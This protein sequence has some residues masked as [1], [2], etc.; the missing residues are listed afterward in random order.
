MSIAFIVDATTSAHLGMG[1]DLWRRYPAVR[2][3]YRDVQTWTGVDVEYLSMR[4]S[5]PELRAAGLLCQTAL[6]FAIS[7]ILAEHGI[8]PSSA[9]GLS[10]GDLIA[11]C[12]AG[13]V[14]REDLCRIMLR[15][16][17]AR[18]SERENAD[19]RLALL[20]VPADVDP[21]TFY[22]PVENVHLVTDL[23]PSKREENSKRMILG[24]REESL[25]ELA[26]ARR[27]GVVLRLLPEHREI[28]RAPHAPR[29]IDTVAFLEPVLSTIAFKQPSVPLCPSV[30][31]KTLVTQQDVAQ[32][33]R[34]EWTHSV[35]L[36]NLQAGL[37]RHGTKVAFILGPSHPGLYGSFPFPV[38]RVETSRDVDRALDLAGKIDSHTR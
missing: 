12:L 18:D 38:V 3:V 35:S 6:A 30:E 15:K 10:T 4:S 11:A 7:D 22:G 25:Q 17:K 36:P 33:F 24:G 9:A 5:A 19:M 34:R 13:G 28:P 37:V 2:A 14:D 29:N 16:M 31:S 32:L 8:F 21:E 27:P 23:G 20:K 26:R 1:E